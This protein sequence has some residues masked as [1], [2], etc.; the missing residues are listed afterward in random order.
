MK[1]NNNVVMGSLNTSQYAAYAN[2]LNSFSSYFYNN[3]VGLRAISMQNEPD[4]NVTYESCVW[5]GT[6]MDTWV[7][8]NSSVL[9]TPL[10]MPESESFI[11]SMSD[12]T[13][14]DSNA[15][16]H[17]NAVAGHIYGVSPTYYTNAFNHGK[18]VWMTEHYISGNNL[19]S[20][21]QI[22]K[23]MV[24]SFSIGNYS[25]YVWWWVFDPSYATGSNMGL[26]NSSVVR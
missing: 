13:L 4:A 24:D 16:G 20:A 15:V 18:P 10:I 26:I 1:S 25:M 2:Y 21:I 5:N 14:N 7:R 6:Q 8:N 22:G 9:Y 11:T 12:P 19:T 23:E 3:G 17:V